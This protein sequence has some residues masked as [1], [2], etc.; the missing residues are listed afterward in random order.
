MNEI[1]KEMKRI[2]NLVIGGSIDGIQIL[3]ELENEPMQKHEY[4]EFLIRT[5][6]MKKIDEELKRRKRNKILITI[7]VFSISLLL[8]LCKK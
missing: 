4:V 5:I 7:T 3:T 6:F 8:Y 2:T 1:E